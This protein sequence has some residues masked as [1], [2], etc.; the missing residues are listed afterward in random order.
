MFLK[1]FLIFSERIMV[2]SS[3]FEK[4]KRKKKKE[5]ESNIIRDGK[6]LLI[7]GTFLSIKK[8]KINTN[9]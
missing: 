2:N 3:T 6:N 4:K 1:N 9:Q 5:N 8:K 7:L